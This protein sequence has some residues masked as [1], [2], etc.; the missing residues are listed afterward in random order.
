MDIIRMR[1]VYSYIGDFTDFLINNEQ[2]IKNLMLD[3]EIQTKVDTLPDKRE[4]KSLLFTKK[5]ITVMLTPNRIDY[6]SNLASPNEKIEDVFLGACSFFKLFSEIFYDLKSSRI[7]IVSQ[8]FIKN[9]NDNAVSELTSK[10]GLANVFGNANELHLKI[11]NPKNLFEPIN[12]VL[13]ISMGEAKNNKTN[14]AVKVLLVSVDVNTLANNL[15][16]RFEICNFEKNFKELFD[17][18]EDKY[19]SLYMY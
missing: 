15:D 6:T 9:D 19:S 3:Y 14:E 18:V 12:S 16:Q 17:E 1:Q 5:N 13:D 11:N 8:A 4:V 7:A 2:R 10:M